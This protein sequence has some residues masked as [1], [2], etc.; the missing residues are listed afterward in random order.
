MMG[1]CYIIYF[2]WSYNQSLVVLYINSS[3]AQV[4]NSQEVSTYFNDLAAGLF[5]D[6]KASL[7][8]EDKIVCDCLS[9][10]QLISHL[11]V[12]WEFTNLILK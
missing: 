10:N 5:M 6:L 2:N 8:L 11:P 12:F 7:L 3:A 9:K 4:T 1:Y